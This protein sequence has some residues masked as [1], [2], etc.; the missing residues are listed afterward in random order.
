[1]SSSIENNSVKLDEVLRRLE[2]VESL[3]MM[4]EVLPDDKE[5][6]LI[7]DYITRAG[8]EENEFIALEEIDNEL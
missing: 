4:G 1:M 2:H 3:L 5:I 8:R 7:R 6:E